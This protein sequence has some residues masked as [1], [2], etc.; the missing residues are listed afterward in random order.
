MHLGI[1]VGEDD[2]ARLRARLPLGIPAVDQI[3]ARR[4]AGFRRMDMI[5]ARIG[6]DRII[7]LARRQ[8]ARGLALPVLALAANLGDLDA[9][10]PLM[11]RAEGCPRLDGL[12]L[13][14]IADHHQLGPASA[15]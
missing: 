5:P 14:R 4:L 15:A 1:G 13:L 3:D 2:P 6:L 8:I 10:M 9:A 7:H 11:D 12:K